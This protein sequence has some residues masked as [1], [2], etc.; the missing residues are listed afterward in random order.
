M[1]AFPNGK[2]GVALGRGFDPDHR[3]DAGQGRGLL[4]EL[5]DKRGQGGWGTF[6]LDFHAL[7]SVAHPAGQVVLPGQ[8]VNKGP[9]ADALHHAGHLESGAGQSL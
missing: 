2:P 3:V 9:E 7:G 5:A 8:P 1:P 4:L 6:D